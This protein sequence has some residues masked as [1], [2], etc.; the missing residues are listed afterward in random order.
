MGKWYLTPIDSYS[1]EPLRKQV[2]KVL[3]VAIINGEIAPGEKITEV[4]IAEEL[5]VS[6]TPVREAFRMLE[7]EEL[8]T[9]I[10]QQG[11]FISGIKSRKEIN[12]IFQ[13][14]MELE[15]LAAYLA[16]RNISNEQI[17]K[18]NEYSERIK[19]CIENNDLKTCVKIDIAFHRIIN[20]ASRNK[21]LEKFLDSLFE[22][23]TRFRSK[24][25]NQ[26][27]R[28]KQALNEHRK[29]GKAIAEGNSELA[30]KLAREHIQGA[31]NSI[32]S[33]FEK[34]KAEEKQK[35]H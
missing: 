9:I 17:N 29:L 24:S 35:E 1:Y 21:W 5:N 15:G 6:R 32:I 7:L 11:V 12:D 10:P 16:A 19:N 28:M 14:R 31:W 23:A 27:G 25:L 30:R 18:L 33:V 13:V 2:Y 3:R 4:E 34:E 20:E 26:K 8:I 22:Q